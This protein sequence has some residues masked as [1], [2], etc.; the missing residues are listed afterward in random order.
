MLQESSHAGVV[1][2]LAKMHVARRGGFKSH[3]GI[4]HPWFIDGEVAGGP[5][6]AGFYICGHEDRAENITAAL[7]GKV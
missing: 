3:I 5:D 6:L 2:V 7:L 1:V 4:K